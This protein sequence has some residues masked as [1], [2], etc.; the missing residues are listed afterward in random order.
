[1]GGSLSECQQNSLYMTTDSTACSQLLGEKYL[2]F[3]AGLHLHIPPSRSTNYIQNFSFSF[4]LLSSSTDWNNSI[5]MGNVCKFANVPMMFFKW[6]SQARFTRIY[7]TRTKQDRGEKCHQ[8]RPDWSLSE[9][10][11]KLIWDTATNHQ[12]NK[13]KQ[14]NRKKIIIIV[15][16]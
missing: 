14:I 11:I 4:R 1:M 7:I 3:F 15:L 8:S 5:Q 13:N 6:Y 2:M 12:R 9:T 16:S 10:R